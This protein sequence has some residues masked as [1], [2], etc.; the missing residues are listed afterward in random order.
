MS[1]DAILVQASKSWLLWGAGQLYVQDIYGSASSPHNHSLILHCFSLPWELCMHHLC[2]QIMYSSCLLRWQ[3]PCSPSTAVGRDTRLRI[4]TKTSQ[5]EKKHISN[6]L[7]VPCIHCPEADNSGWTGSPQW[8]KDCI[9]HL[10][11][12]DVS[13]WGKHHVILGKTSPTFECIAWHPR[14]WPQR[15]V[16]A[17]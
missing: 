1:Q 3:M 13:L 2:V 10:L 5:G 6:C 11:K 14:M 9:A 7:E 15:N 12:E 8:L 4:E 16:I 17:W